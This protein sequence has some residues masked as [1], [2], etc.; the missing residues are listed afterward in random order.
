M[1]MPQGLTKVKWAE[2][3]EIL[4]HV[5]IKARSAAWRESMEFV[6]QI[7]AGKNNITPNCDARTMRYSVECGICRELIKLD[8]DYVFHALTASYVHYDCHHRS[9]GNIEGAA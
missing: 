5:P 2:L 6:D 7:L 3:K 4:L 1:A 9:S 8:E